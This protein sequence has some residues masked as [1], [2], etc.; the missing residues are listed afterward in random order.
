MVSNLR[1]NSQ[2]EEETNTRDKR[3]ISDD[4]NIVHDDNDN[5]IKKP[6]TEDVPNPLV[7][8]PKIFKENPMLDQIKLANCLLRDP[9]LM[10]AKREWE[11]EENRREND[12]KSTPGLSP[13]LSLST[14]SASSND[15]NQKTSLG[16]HSVNSNTKLMEK[17]TNG[18]II[19]LTRKS[20]FTHISMA[21]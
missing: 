7:T 19:I 6:K 1:L 14:H 10:K 9:S 13:S 21:F 17:V 3:K 5:D 11:T 18:Q 4:L 2:K 15:F 8:Q 12:R 20:F 16:K